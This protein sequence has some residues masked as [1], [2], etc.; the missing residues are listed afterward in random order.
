MKCTYVYL[1][2]YSTEGKRSIFLNLT[3][4]MLGARAEK[5]YHKASRLL[6]LLQPYP[7]STIHHGRSGT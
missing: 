4:K 5:I 7:S 1:C 6:F 3:K 2:T